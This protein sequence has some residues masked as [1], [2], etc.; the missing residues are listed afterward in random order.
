MYRFIER[1]Y[2]NLLVNVFFDL[3]SSKSIELL[4]VRPGIFPYQYLSGTLIQL[5]GITKNKHE[6]SSVGGAILSTIF[7]PRDE[8]FPLATDFPGS[9]SSSYK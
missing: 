1:Y 9:S 5:L 7:A 4:I 2:L 8:R 3:I 6:L